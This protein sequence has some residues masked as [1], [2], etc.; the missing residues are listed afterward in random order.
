MQLTSTIRAAVG[1]GL[2]S[3]VPFLAEAQSYVRDNSFGTSGRVTQNF[4][5]ATPRYSTAASL[6]LPNDQILAAV[7]DQTTNDLR[8]L[9]FLPDGALDP[10]FGTNGIV[11]VAPLPAG[12]TSAV[13]AFWRQAQVEVLADGSVLR[14]GT[15]GGKFALVRYLPDG[16]L[17]TAFGTGGVAIINDAYV[18]AR[19][20]R[21]P[22]GKIVV[23]G[24]TT[25]A[26]SRTDYHMVVT[27][28][29]ATGSPDFTTVVPFG[30]PVSG[31]MTGNVHVMGY[32]V[33]LQPDGKI[34]AVG[35]GTTVRGNSPYILTVARL[36]PNGALDNTYGTNG[37]SDLI[38]AGALNRIRTSVDALLQ[39]DGKLVVARDGADLD[40]IRLTT[41]GA[42]DPTFGSQGV[43][44]LSSSIERHIPCCGAR[45]VLALSDN[46]LLALYNNTSMTAVRLTPTGQ[47]DPSFLPVPLTFMHETFPGYH[48]TTTSVLGQQ[49]NNRLVFVGQVG[50]SA[51]FGS[52]SNTSL[53]G[54]LRMA[55][56]PNVPVKWTGAV[57]SDWNAAGNWHTGAVPTATDE[58]VIL[59]PVYGG[60]MPVLTGNASVKSLSHSREATLTLAPGAKL[61]AQG[62]TNL[63]GTTS[64]TGTLA[65]ESASGGPARIYSADG[66]STVVLPELLVGSA[67][68]E[69]YAPLT[70]TRRLRLQG[71]LNTQ[72]SFQTPLTLRSDAAG[73][74][75]VTAEGGSVT[76]TVRVQR[77]LD[78][79]NNAGLGYRHLSAPVSNATA[80]GLAAPGF[81]PVLNQAYN[82]AQNPGS[83]T[84]FPNVFQFDEPRTGGGQSFDR[85]WQVP[86]GSLAVGRGYSVNVAGGTTLT[87]TGTLNGGA[88]NLPLQYSGTGAGWNLLGNPYPAP[89]DWDRITV[90]AGVD[91][92][93]FLFRSSGPY[94]GSYSAY[95]NGIGGPNLVPAMQGFFLR[96]SAPGA[97]LQ[98]TDAARVTDYVNP[99][100][101]RTNDP[102]AQLRLDLSGPGQSQPAD[103]VHVYLQ[104]GATPDFDTALDAAKLMP[105]G[106]LPALHTVSANGQPLAIDGRPLLTGTA[107]VVP[108]AVLTPQ[109]GTYT[110]TAGALANL[111]GL[112]VELEDL[113]TGQRINLQTT[114]SYTFAATASTTAVP[115]FR[116]LLN[117]ARPTATAQAKAAAPSLYPNPAAAGTL[118]RVL[119]PNT[120]ELLLCDALGRVLRHVPVGAGRAEVNTTGLAPGV[121]LVRAAN[122]ATATRLLVH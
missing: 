103:A 80:S 112:A 3:S 37:R 33:L 42:A 1:I 75:L 57:S 69:L 102:R 82:T 118:V 87:F 117:A 83:V 63:E 74:A 27:R 7:L 111:A 68:A 36:L 66:Q 11:S 23:V 77:Y 47:V 115:R 19:F 26:G 109:A 70:L 58:V 79:G 95:V 25:N 39:A 91:A 17:D 94:A 31:S 65:L 88:Y 116:L 49:S 78:P 46:G 51:I 30:V 8:V 71:P 55:P 32:S 40:L 86:S 96:A 10:S 81:T 110:L 48:F 35:G 85:G 84:P 90:P 56:L 16:T 14:S 18:Y 106:S 73:T 92:A 64:G 54:M 20:T 2:L 28:L 93:L 67:G 44:Q 5:N 22:D 120:T 60:Y 104:A 119:T 50:T 61:T 38:P 107:T 29:S 43:V 9:R 34:V 100:V 72:A 21:Q 24:S 99:A 101:L 113:T 6:V 52:G 59:R 62:A 114:P 12:F 45:P 121:Y 13:T 105:S 76:G 89:L 15:S 122:E 98:L 108:L 41:S 53:F 4:G 97:T